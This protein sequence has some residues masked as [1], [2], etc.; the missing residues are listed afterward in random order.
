MPTSQKRFTKIHIKININSSDHSMKCAFA[1]IYVLFWIRCWI[2]FK[3][4]LSLWSISVLF[5][6]QWN[7]GCLYLKNVPSCTVEPI[8]KFLKL[9]RCQFIDGQKIIIPGKEV[10]EAFWLN[11]MR[12]LKK[13]WDGGSFL[14]LHFKLKIFQGIQEMLLDLPFSVWICVG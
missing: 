14:L 13:E 4:I 8:F 11:S 7:F 2:K 1:Q 12:L 5:I 3:I 6:F 9:I 10:Y